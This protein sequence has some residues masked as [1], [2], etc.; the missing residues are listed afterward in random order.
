MAFSRWKNLEQPSYPKCRSPTD[1]NWLSLLFQMSAFNSRKSPKHQT[2]SPS[3]APWNQEMDAQARML[4]F[5]LGGGTAYDLFSPK[6]SGGGFGQLQ[7]CHHLALWWQNQ[8]TAMIYHRITL[9]GMSQ[10]LSWNVCPTIYPRRRYVSSQEGK[11]PNIS[12]DRSRSSLQVL[13]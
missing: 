11:T 2:W 10:Y 1:S 5:F 7:V 13:R 4:F 6:F 12:G 3:S 9:Q 8:S